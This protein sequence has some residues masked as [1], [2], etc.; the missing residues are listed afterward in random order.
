[1]TNLFYYF[2]HSSAPFQFPGA[3]F[4]LGFMVIQVDHADMLFMLEQRLDKLSQ[5]MFSN[6]YILYISLLIDRLLID[7]PQVEDITIS[8][9]VDIIIKSSF[10]PNF[11]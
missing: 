11:L 9:R 7:I 4:F 5:N 1:M 3:P 10:F 8:I 2:T 6:Q